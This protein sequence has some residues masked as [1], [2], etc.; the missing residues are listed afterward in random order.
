MFEC[1]RMINVDTMQGTQLNTRQSTALRQMI[2]SGEI[3]GDGGEALQLSDVE[4]CGGDICLV[5]C[6]YQAAR[7]ALA[8]AESSRPGIT[9]TR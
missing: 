4:D 6:A 8:R 9:E 7:A 1:C 2:S 5:D 3:R